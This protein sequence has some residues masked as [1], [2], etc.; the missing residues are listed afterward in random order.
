MTS[1]SHILVADLVV[2]ELTESSAPAS[3]DT[4][5]VKRGMA[6]GMVLSSCLLSGMFIGINWVGPYIV[7]LL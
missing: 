1:S 5:T 7:S 3:F 2:P 4:G 6:L